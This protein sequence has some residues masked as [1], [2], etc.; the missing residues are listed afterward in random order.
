M[1]D[2]INS[3][4]NMGNASATLA[5][6]NFARADQISTEFLLRLIRL[7]G[8]DFKGSLIDQVFNEAA[9]VAFINSIIE[10]VEQSE[11]DDPS[12]ERLAHQEKP[13]LLICRHKFG[14]ASVSREQANFD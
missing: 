11:F 14:S 6:V 3:A 13:Q 1:L 10:E 4:R 12:P 2:Q 7:S 5:R 9:A 8:E